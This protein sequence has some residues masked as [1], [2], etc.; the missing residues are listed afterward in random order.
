M[1]FA[2]SWE[3]MG[4][5]CG[6]FTVF[7][8]IQKKFSPIKLRNLFFDLAKTAGIQDNTKT[9]QCNVMIGCG[10]VSW[11]RRWVGGGGGVEEPYTDVELEV[12]SSLV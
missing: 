12:I 4:R 1:G 9:E 5:C 11:Y 10:W 3:Q 8:L 7:F 2:M 6:Y